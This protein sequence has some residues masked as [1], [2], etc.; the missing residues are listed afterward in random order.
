MDE[1]LTLVFTRMLQPFLPSKAASLWFEVCLLCVR[2]PISKR[3]YCVK[4][5]PDLE[6]ERKKSVNQLFQIAFGNPDRTMRRHWFILSVDAFFSMNDL[7]KSP[8]SFY[9]LRLLGKKIAS[10]IAFL[11]ES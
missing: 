4:I 3:T 11:V 9:D 1:S 2:F 7:L 6:K 8:P 5:I 10:V